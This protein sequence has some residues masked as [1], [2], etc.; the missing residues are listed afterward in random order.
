MF[1]KC[2][3][4]GCRETISRRYLFCPRHWRMVP[5]EMKKHWLA[6]VSA[7]QERRSGSAKVLVNF[8]SEFRRVISENETLSELERIRPISKGGGF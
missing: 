4:Q 7:Y 8:V 3:A 6:V 5:P 2:H 1:R